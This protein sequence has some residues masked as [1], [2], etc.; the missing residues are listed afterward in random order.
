MTGSTDPVPRSDHRGR[1]AAVRRALADRNLDA[2]VLT[3]AVARRWLTGF[4]G[5]NGSVLVTDDRL[6]VVTDGRYQVQVGADLAATGLDSQA[7]VVI[8]RDLNGAIAARVGGATRVGLEA[9]RTTW[10]AQLALAGALDTI[11]VVP[12]MGFV[13]ALRVVKDAAEIA[14]LQRAAALADRALDEV[15]P[16]LAGGP[17]E[18]EVARRLDDAMRRSGADAPSFDTIVASGPNSARPH[19]RPSSRAIAD[20]DLVI[21]DMGARVDGYGSDMTRTFLVG[22][23]PDRARHIYEAVTRSQLAGIEVVRAGAEERAVDAAC[24]S[25]LEADGL[26]DAFSHGT[27]HGIG[28]EI[29]EDPFLSS[30]SDGVVAAGSVITVEPGVYLEGFGGVRI[31]DSLVVTD[32][33]S[34]PLTRAPKVPEIPFHHG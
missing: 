7:E 22:D 10:A 29:H 13:A 4:T 9:E 21:I 25:S 33:G 31:E 28:L 20:G 5:S 15:R 26:A 34:I 16:M 3:D 12:L 11:D 23:V 24:R 2:V 30:R 6:V 19:H 18:A 27:G 32:D 14:A 17:T 1:L 8:D